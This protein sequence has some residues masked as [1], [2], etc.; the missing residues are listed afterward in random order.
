M[1]LMAADQTWA[2]E[3]ACSQVDPDS[4]FV[5]GAAQRQVRQVCFSCPVR[6]NCLADA[7]DSET[8]FGVWGGLT[9]RERRALLR[10][11]PDETDWY[12]RLMSSDDPIAQD[13]RAGRVP[14]LGLR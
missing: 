14:R 11:Y 2:A 10:R 9:E 6:L 3:A 12:T 7:L 5:R 4:L 1:S 13:L 8:S